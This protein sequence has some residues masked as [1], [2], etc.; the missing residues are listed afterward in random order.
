MT[1]RA[2]FLTTVIAAL[3]VAPT[4]T[5]APWARVTPEDGS[6]TDQVGFARTGD[7]VLHL[8]WS[9]PTGPNT[10][11][12]L[13]TVISRDG[14]VGATNPIQSGWTGFSNP[15]LVVDPGGLRAFWGGFRSTDS[16]DP[17][18]EINTALSSDGG[19][20]WA[21]MAGQV[22][23][24][25]GQ[26]Y[27]SPISATVRNDGTTVQAWSGT[28]GTWVHVGL[29]PDEK[30]SPNHNYMEGRQYGND[31]NIVTDA[32]GRVWMAWYSNDRAGF[33]VLA[34][35]VGA[36]GEPLG[37]PLTMP[38]TSAMNIGMIGRT[39]LVARAGGGV[40]TAYP[41]PQDQSQ[42]RVWRV[43]AA[44]APIVA[45]KSGSGPVAIAKAD[46]GRL[47][48]LWDDKGGLGA[49]IHARRSNRG[50]TRWGAEVSA[51]RPRGTLQSYRLDAS[52]IGGAVDVLGVFNLGT[53][54]NAATF[55]R[56]LLPGLTLTASPGRLRRGRPTEVRFTVRDAGDAVRGARVSAGGRSGTTDGRGR[57]EL[58]LPGRATR[59]TA[60]K[61]G[62]AEDTLRLQAR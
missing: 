16:S 6:G 1:L 17:Q 26:A 49:T 43:G 20:S 9:R 3:A 31:P 53:S 44:N 41:T 29:N 60:T 42:V 4:A 45:R 12:L 27:A 15:A 61:T 38:G 57:V 11:D 2:A 35:Q 51:G 39:P 47:W 10:E 14:R 36:G 40:Y 7:G 62:Y 22:N 30:V 28:L 46:D 13:H 50:A 23:P 54:T 37:S 25:G 5:A 48:V 24:G 21:L 59:A 34:Q 56:R 33:G 32:A 8:A 58:T 52:A 55:H 19:A 18:R